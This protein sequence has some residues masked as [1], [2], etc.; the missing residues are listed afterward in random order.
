MKFK[1]ALITLLL[2][3]SAII[4]GQFIGKMC[5]DISALSWLSY[6][7]SFGFP[8]SQPFVLDLSVLQLALGF[9]VSINVAQITLFVLALFLYK[10]LLKRL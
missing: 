2:F 5:T 1:K 4:L 10:P 9:Y 6:A 8:V 7:V 3:V